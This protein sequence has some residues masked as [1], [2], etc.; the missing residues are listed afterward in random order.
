MLK[1]EKPKEVEDLKNLMESYSLVGILNMHKLPTR[2][3]Q[4]IKKQLGS[5]AVIRM[6]RKSMLS[7]ALDASQKS[8]LKEKIVGEPA[9]IL[10]NESPFKLFR[11]LKENRASA[12][13][14]AGDIAKNDIV[15]AKGPTSLPPG[16]AISTL[17][18][19][20]LKTTVQAGKIAVSQDK[21]VAKSG[22]TVNDDMVGAFNLLKMEPMEIGL[23]MVVALEKGTLYDKSVLDIDIDVYLKNLQ[24][25]VQ[26]AINISLHTG[27]LVPETAVL[28]V[29]KA[30]NEAKSLCI[31]ANILEKE[32]I[33]DVLAKAVTEAKALEKGIADKTA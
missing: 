24:L 13:A 28:S 11:V 27:Y 25:A 31:A 7:R 29:Q 30:F 2:Q 9:L 14:K 23:D 5:R 17:Q 20:G 32:F 4:K 12:P 15:I 16:P 6:S 19:I 3:L 18:K 26:H 22:E 21:V 10:S 33:G 1:N 8:A